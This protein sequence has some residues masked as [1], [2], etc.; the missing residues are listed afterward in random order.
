M[1]KSN[2]TKAH[3]IYRLKDGTKVVGTTTITNILAKPALVVWANRIGLQGID[4]AKYVDDKADIGTLA[5]AI[6]TNELAGKPTDTSDYSKNQI[7]SAENSVLSF[8][9]WKKGKTIEPI[10]IEAPLV[11][12]EH[13]YGGTMDVYA[14]I[15]GALELLDLKTGSG[16]WPEHFYQ[17][18]GGY[19]ELLKENLFEVERIRILNIPRTKDESFQEQVVKAEDCG[20]YWEIFYHCL[21]IYELKKR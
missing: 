8:Y 21:R 11:S 6:I 20:L 12:E 17:V 7:S 19:L 9:E 13:R 4:V 2:K 1:T 5:H 3:T 16:I 10:L 18:G 14:K 15:D